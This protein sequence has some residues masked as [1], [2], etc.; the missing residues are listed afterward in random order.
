MKNVYLAL[1]LVATLFGM[2]LAQESSSGQ[3][4]DQNNQSTVR[5]C[6]QA[7]GG[8]FF[9]T[10][11]TGTT[12]HLAGAAAEL[13]KLAG[14]E[15]QVTGTPGAPNVATGQSAGAARASGDTSATAPLTMQATNV[16]KVGDR[17]TTAAA[18]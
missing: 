6:L 7:N 11:D 2:L 8:R 15:V 16:K 3:S 4:A 9:L 18:R 14:K 13:H 5:G 17:C 10:A 1:A 12:Y